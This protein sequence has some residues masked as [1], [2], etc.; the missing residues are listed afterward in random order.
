[1]IPHILSGLTCVER[2]YSYP[3]LGS[4]NDIAK[5]MERKPVKGFYVIQ[6]DRLSSGSE[7]GDTT[8]FPDNNSGL[9]VS[10]VT[11]VDSNNTIFTY[12]RALVLAIITALS[13]V[14]PLKKLS[15]KWPDEIYCDD[16][17][18]GGIHLET[19]SVFSEVIVL[20]F[21]L[22][23]NTTRDEFPETL[24]EVATSLFIE[25]G[26][27]QS[28]GI[29]LRSILSLY[30]QNTRSEHKTIHHYYSDN[31]YKKGKNVEIAGMRGV[32]EG[33]DSEG[34]LCLLKDGESILISSG[35][36]VFF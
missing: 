5:N 21:G 13:S 27:R 30:Y 29:L 17:K 7:Q 18:I 24:Q 15:I 20:G 19:H 16:L 23:I 1:M 2:F 11:N 28:P 22:Y 14:A 33:I 6:A 8:F 25:T 32:F 3:E 10:V 26:V 36:A 31:L 9:W 4:T 34:R 12:N 35:S